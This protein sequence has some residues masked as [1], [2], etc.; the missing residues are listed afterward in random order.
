MNNVFTSASTCL[1]IV[2]FTGERPIVTI[3]T[4]L[5]HDCG[6]HFREH[7]VFLCI[8]LVNCYEFCSVVRVRVNIFEWGRSE[9]SSSRTNTQSYQK[10]NIPT[11][12]IFGVITRALLISLHT[13]PPGSTIISSQT[14]KSGIQLK[15][16]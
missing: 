5:H 9:F 15:S 8:L 14:V 1:L 16:K 3:F 4:G 11:V 10:Q 2:T 6:H 13:V 7:R 12:A